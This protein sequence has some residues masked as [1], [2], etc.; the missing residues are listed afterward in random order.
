MS[1][2]FAQA[3]GNPSQLQRN[4]SPAQRNPNQTHRNPNQPQR[5]PNAFSFRESKLLNGLSSNSASGA[6]SEPPSRLP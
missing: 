5:N 1:S 6:S 3:Q 4:Q 2:G